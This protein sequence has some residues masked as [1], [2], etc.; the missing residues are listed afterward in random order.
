MKNLDATKTASTIPVRIP[1]VA[2]VITVILLL[3]L[4]FGAR[5]SADPASE[6][7]TA[8]YLDAIRT[9]PLLL[10]RFMQELPKGGDLHNHGSGAV[11]AERLIDWALKDGLCVDTDY[12]LRTCDEG[13]T[14]L[15]TQIR[16][17]GFRDHLIDAISMRS[18]TP[19]E[20]SGHDHFFN[21]FGK[22][23]AATARHRTDIVAEA[24]RQA[25]QDH[26]DYL[27]LMLTF[28][29]AQAA[30]S[31]AD[32][33]KGI[34][35][36]GDFDKLRAA[37]DA[38]G[39]AKVVDATQRDLQALESARASKMHCAP[40]NAQREPGCDVQ[41]RYLQQVIRNL[42]P[43]TVFAQ[44]MLGF[45]LAQRDDRL[46]GVNFVSPEDGPVA[47]RD[48]ALHMRMIAYLRSAVGEVPVTLH[49]GELTLGLVPR[50]VLE[51]HITQAVEVAGARRI[52]HGVDIAYERDEPALLRTMANRH[53]LVEIALTSN[54]VILGVRGADHPIR[55]YVQSGVPIALVTDDEGVSRIDLSNEFVRAA[56]DY[57]FSYPTFKGFVR[58][59]IEYAFVKGKSLWAD[60]AKGKPVAVCAQLA[61]TDACRNFLAANSRA[62]ME[63]KLERRLDDFERSISSEGT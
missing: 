16:L 10:R 39:F 8:R 40:A 51:D 29:N 48:Y 15:A 27:E 44:T 18:F 54:D 12:S 49:A 62:A 20:E 45:E 53:V 14:R 41:L 35:F 58:N 47:V 50:E 23:G 17:A 21:A 30:P 61:A 11:Y 32:V 31:L 19:R 33:T 42:D 25:A 5:A 7:A 57:G 3:V 9:Q 4:S 28:G 38:N 2:R 13:G 55:L 22:F 63:W 59:S 60:E 46:V 56:R 26:V 43:V 34:T 24:L 36:D 52:G 37:L 1:I 6:R